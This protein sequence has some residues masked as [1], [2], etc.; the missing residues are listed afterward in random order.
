[1]MTKDQKLAIRIVRHQRKADRLRMIATAD[2]M[3]EAFISFFHYKNRLTFN[4]KAFLK[5][6]G[7]D[8]GEDED[9]YRPAHG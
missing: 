5:A 7:L 2:T 4:E 1:M 6:C 8:D 9:Y 3:A